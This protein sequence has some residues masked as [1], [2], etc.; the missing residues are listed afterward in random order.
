[1]PGQPVRIGPFVG[2]MNTYSGP[3]AIGDNEA[4][5]IINLDIDLDGALA[6]RPP[7]AIETAPVAEASHIIGVYRS[8]LD[9]V[10][11]IYAFTG[12]VRAYNTSDGSWT[13]IAAVAA[14]ACIQY[15]DKLYIVRAPSGATQG[16]YKWDPVGGAAAIAAMPRG[17]SACVYKERMFISASRNGDETSINRV[18]F[19]NPA[20]PEAWTSTDY[21]DASAGDGQDITKLFVFDSGIVIFKTDSTYVFAYE[22]D[23]S[24]GQV[25]IVSSR[26]GANN[27]FSVIE[28]EN[29]MFVMHESKVYRISNWNWEHA[30][31]KIPF[32]YNNPYGISIA[33]GSSLSLLNN[34]LVCRY[35]SN[36]YVMGLKTGA[37]AKWVFGDRKNILSN[38]TFE[39]NTTGWSAGGGRMDI[40]RPLG[41]PA[42]DG[43]YVM[44]GTANVA[45]GAVS[46]YFGGPNSTPVIGETYTASF[47]VRPP[48]DGT[49][50]C[51]LISSTGTGSTVSS[52]HGTPTFCPAGVWTRLSVTAQHDPVA[53]NIRVYAYNMNAMVIGDYFEVDAILNEKGDLLLP[54]FS[55]EL[56]YAPSE[57]I[58]NPNISPL[59]GATR[60]FAGSTTS[61]APN[62][63]YFEDR[64][65]GFVE[66]IDT[67][68]VTKSYDFGP[69]Y[70]FK[71]LF[72]WGV[73]L[74]SRARITFKV[75]PVVYAVPTTWGQLVGIP[76]TSLGTW[77]RPLEPSLDVTDEVQSKNPSGARIFAKIL[78]SL[79]FRQVFFTLES[80]VDGTSATGPLRVFS[81]TASVESK[82]Q[83]V[84]KVS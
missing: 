79:R 49:F 20:N 51:T 73:D 65:S 22:S 11:I 25:Q 54:Y 17:F 78:K 35:F 59:T 15:N 10:Y 57:F 83:V 9:V 45:M 23:P 69:S 1:M 7:V 84:K 53:T 34:R 40:T 47:Y 2:G 77:G 66:K 36:Y 46:G 43:I 42:V 38:S 62:F 12:S 16:G 5:E 18:K 76:F 8:T 56:V 4:V 37:W 81:L 64:I 67:R 24:K 80:T 21:F 26:I 27:N 74:L 61:Q 60:Y 63:Y 50:R 52:V 14:T 71:R 41:A 28:F 75:T 33:D 68:L 44:R 13:T 70:S 6:S 72:W 58:E 29:N 82:Q 30:N 48:V 55:G 39:G 19:S 31:F 32:E 3:S